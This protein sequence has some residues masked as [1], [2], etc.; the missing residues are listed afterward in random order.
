MLVR[1]LSNARTVD[2]GN[3]LSRRF[4]MKS[5]GVGYT[6]TDTLIRAGSRSRLRYE[7]HIEACYC[8]EGAGW[9][10]DSD[11]RRYRIEPGT[12]YALDERDAHCLVAD[13]E[14]DMRLVCVFAPALEGDET[15]DLQA[16]GYSTYRSAREQPGSPAHGAA[17]AGDASR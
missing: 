1:T 5:D 16:D 8:I 10:I 6:L 11:E 3:G 4:L 13:D 9:V 7:N 14:Q 15:H 12:L 17:L 2:W